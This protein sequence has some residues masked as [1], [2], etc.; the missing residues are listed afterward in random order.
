MNAAMAEL[1]DA[2]TQ[3]FGGK[4]RGESDNGR[5]RVRVAICGF[6]SRPLQTP[7]PGIGAGPAG[8]SGDENC[9]CGKRTERKKQLFFGPAA[10]RVKR[11]KM[12]MV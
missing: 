8:G 12:R 1:A 7:Y 9:L 10:R 5:L 2:R 11:A 3:A 4:Q 6:D